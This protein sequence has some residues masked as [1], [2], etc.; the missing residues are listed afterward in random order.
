M[1]LPDP[2]ELQLQLAELTSAHKIKQYEARLLEVDKQIISVMLNLTKLTK[3]KQDIATHLEKA[4]GE[5]HG[6][7]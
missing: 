1:D 7:L 4:R 3:E 6:R 2:N 5:T